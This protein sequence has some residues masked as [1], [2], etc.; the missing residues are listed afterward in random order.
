MKRVCRV[1]GFFNGANNR[2][3]RT[4]NM[5]SALAVALGTALSIIVGTA[6]SAAIIEPIAGSNVAI[7][8][9]GQGF[10]TVTEPAIANPGDLVMVSLTGSANVVY[11]DGCKIALQPG[12]VMAIA[13]LSPCAAR[14][15]AQA[16][17]PD[18]PLLDQAG[19]PAFSAAALG[20]T[21]FLAYEIYQA[22]KPPG[23]APQPASP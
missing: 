18:N 22:N 14:S 21:G 12:A 5:R 15:N 3:H 6:C 9:Q 1:D 10:Q 13:P 17:G 11:P 23:A 4:M 16:P 7:N 20:L 2:T 19:V 8:R